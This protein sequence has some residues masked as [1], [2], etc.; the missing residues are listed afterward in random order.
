[1]TSHNPTQ[2]PSVD[3]Q[4]FEAAVQPEQFLVTGGLPRPPRFV[5]FDAL[6][7]LEPRRFV[8]QRLDPHVHVA[9]H[10]AGGPSELLRDHVLRDDLEERVQ[11]GVDVDPLADLLLEE[12][13]HPLDDEVDEG[14][15]V[16]H[17]HFLH[18][19]GV[20]FLDADEE[21]L[22]DGGRHLEEVLEE[23]DAGVEDVD[24]AG[25]AHLLRLQAEVAYHQHDLHEVGDV[26]GFEVGGGGARHRDALA[27]GGDPRHDH[28]APEE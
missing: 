24:V 14:R 9:L 12:G 16:D 19:D 11:V 18:L 26:G 2:P 23:G 3:R 17:V 25:H 21:L 6:L 4:L 13:R 15:R 28:S 20:G 7:V 10:L 27:V 5:R 22:H 1:L 8:L